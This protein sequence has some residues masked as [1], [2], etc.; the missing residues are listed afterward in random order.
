MDKKII[1]QIE[2]KAL[3]LS[4]NSK[5]PVSDIC[6]LA[7]KHSLPYKK[8]K[9][10]DAEMPVLDGRCLVCGTVHNAK[11]SYKLWITIEKHEFDPQTG[12]EEFTDIEECTRSAGNFDTEEEALKQMNEIGE[13][14]EGDFRSDGNDDF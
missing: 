13:A 2:K 6:D 11:V 12:K 5:T 7:N 14:F 9:P 1:K 3:K 10:C 8:C 4:T